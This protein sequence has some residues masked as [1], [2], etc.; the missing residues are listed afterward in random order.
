MLDAPLT[1]AVT[2][3]Y[4]KMGSKLLELGADPTITFDNWIKA[5]LAKMPYAKSHTAENNKDSYYS[6]V[7][8]PI[9]VA[10]AKEMGKSVEDLLAHGADP[11]TL[12]K[13]SYNL[14]KPENRWNTRYQIPDSLLDII[15]KKLKALR[16]HKVE[17]NNTHM[18]TPE[19]LH[20]EQHYTVGLSSESYQFWSASHDILVKKRSNDRAHKNYQEHLEKKKI[21]DGVAEKK[22]AISKLIQELEEAEKALLDAGAQSFYDL[23]RDIPKPEN[24]NPQHSY[25][26]LT[27]EA[28]AYETFFYFTLPDL[29][30]TKRAGC[31]KLFEAAWANDFDTIKSM[32]LTPWGIT[33]AP[34]LKIAV[35]DGNGFSPFSL[36]VLR[37]HYDLAKKIVEICMAQYYDDDDRTIRQRWHMRSSDSDDDISDDGEDLPIFSELINDKYTV[38]NL[39]EVSN[40]VKSNVLPIS[41]IEWTCKAKRILETDR[42]RNQDQESLLEYAVDQDDMTLLKFII[43]LASEQQAR[44]AAE[45]DDQKCYTINRSVFYKAIELGRTRMLASMIESSG[46]GIPLNE[47]IS[48]SGIEIKSKPRYYQG[49]TV[50]GKKRKDWAQA[51]DQFDHVVEERIPPLLQAAHMGSL[52]SLEW[53]MSDASLRRYKEFAAKNKHDKR[54]Q[55]LEQDGKGFDKTIGAWLGKS[56]MFDSLSPALPQSLSRC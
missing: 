50:G 46:V 18:N 17:P 15:Q 39:G 34:P 21:N 36:A 5:Y 40:V 16:E 30:D 27:Y 24:I 48:K 54:I 41:M 10:A 45:P 23:H 11:N 47:L 56:S 33:S 55:A 3:G 22:E 6:S 29:N 1:T 19:T 4:G 42:D 31:V 7:M 37:G 25:S 52:D 20:D 32:T 53:F 28:S 8:Q 14:A 43:K 9:I 35:Q 49:L 51:P 44:L 38:D 13:G 26:Q 12:E 2:K